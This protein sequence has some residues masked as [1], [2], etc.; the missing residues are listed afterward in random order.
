MTGDAILSC[1]F[2]RVDALG[3]PAATLR[4]FFRSGLSARLAAILFRGL[5]L[6]FAGRMGALLLVRWHDVFLSTHKFR[7][8][9]RAASS[10]D[11]GSGVVEMLAKRESLGAQSCRGFYDV[12]G[13]RFQGF[14]L[15]VSQT[16]ILIGCDP[17]T[18]K[19]ATLK[20]EP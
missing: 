14:T 20:P 10:I 9:R 17:E 11:Y 18:L 2:L 5:N 13:L 4:M 19:P 1:R 6:T 8:R 12:T 15:Q 3:M 16:Q 7:S